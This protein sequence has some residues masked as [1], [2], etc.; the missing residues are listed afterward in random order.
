MR[1][2]GW[3]FAAL[4]VGLAAARIGVLLDDAGAPATVA[5]MREPRARAHR[6]ARRAAAGVGLRRDRRVRDLAPPGQP[7]RLAADHDRR[8]LRAAALRRAARLAPARWTAGSGAG[9]LWLANWVWIVAVIAAV[10]RDP[11]AVPE[12]A[13][14][15][16]RLAARAVG[17]DRRH[18]GVHARDDARARP[19][20][21]L[22][23]DREPVRLCRVPRRAARRL[24]RG[25]GRR[26]AR[27]GLLAVLPLPPRAGDRARA[28]Q[29]GVG[30]RRRA[31][32]HVRDQRRVRGVSPDRGRQRL[33]RRHPR[34]CRS[35]SPG[36]APPT[37][38]RRR[39]RRQPHAR[40][41]RP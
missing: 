15:V 4:T 17:D 35:R 39:R 32:R 3:V 27:V 33:P 38:L 34:A 40:L 19:A 37:P 23:G 14:A 36:D 10:R 41:R 21:E 12:R 13:A 30:G 31:D 9:W 6:R 7:D 22:S 5:G 20:R 25:P 26:R 24:L 11:A 16:A 18:R 2:L 1:R 28:D 29:V 8:G